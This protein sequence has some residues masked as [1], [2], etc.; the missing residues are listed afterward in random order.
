MTHFEIHFPEYFDKYAS[1]TE[2][3]GY[4]ADV[5]VLAGGR[6]YR[7]V[8]YDAIRFQQEMRDALEARGAFSERN[9]VIVPSVTRDQIV[10]AIG[11]LAASDFASL[12]PE[13][14]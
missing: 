13:A 2:A 1:E 9:V 10:S 7:P 11:E 5:T 4:F 14:G 6:R 3:K 8:F 12:M